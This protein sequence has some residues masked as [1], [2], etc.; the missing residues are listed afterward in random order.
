MGNA[1]SNQ[2]SPHDNLCDENQA[3]K[4]VEE[5]VRSRCVRHDVHE[6]CKNE[7][8]VAF[9]AALKKFD[10]EYHAPFNLE[11]QSFLDAHHAELKELG[12]MPDDEAEKI[13]YEIT[14]HYSSIN[15]IDAANSV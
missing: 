2:T 12:A 9:A 3:R 15:M 1:S 14:L 11:E 7:R 10:E 13:R 5:Y 8:K 6:K 4:I